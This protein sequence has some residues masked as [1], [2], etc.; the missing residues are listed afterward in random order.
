M[1]LKL[2]PTIKNKPLRWLVNTVFAVLFL[3]VLL[4]GAVR[5]L[6]PY[7]DGQRAR[8]EQ[9][10]SNTLNATVS[11]ERIDSHWDGLLPYLDLENVRIAPKKSAKLQSA[12]T[13]KRLSIGADVLKMIRA[14]S[15][16][17]SHMDLDGLTVILAQ[18]AKGRWRV[19]GLSKSSDD[20]T[21]TNINWDGLIRHKQVSVK[22]AQLKIK[23]YREKER[24]WIRSIQAELNT[25]NGRVQAM[26]SLQPTGIQK[27]AQQAVAKVHVDVSGSINDLET[28]SGLVN[29]HIPKTDLKKLNQY[30]DF[31][32]SLYSGHTRLA[33]DIQLEDGKILSSQGELDAALKTPK[34]KAE[35]KTPIKVVDKDAQI[36]LEAPAPVILN[37]QPLQPL[38]QSRLE[39]DTHNGFSLGWRFAQLDAQKLSRGVSQ[40]LRKSKGFWQTL[41]GLNIKGK[42][43][44]GFLGWSLES[45]ITAYGKMDEVSWQA[46]KSIPAVSGLS[47]YVNHRGERTIVTMDDAFTYNGGTLFPD[48]I[49]VTQAKGELVFDYSGQ[50]WQ[51][52]TTDFLLNTAH[53]DSQ[54]TV[55][56]Q[57]D[58]NATPEIALSSNIQNGQLSHAMRYVPRTLTPQTLAWFKQAFISGVIPNASVQVKGPVNGLFEKGKK[59]TFLINARVKDADFSYSKTWPKV[60]KVSGQFKMN[61]RRLSVLSE[62]GD[63]LGLKP[64]EVS[65]VIPNLAKSSME[66]DIK[67]SKMPMSKIVYFLKHSP[68]NR[69]IG[70]AISSFSGAGHA[71]VEFGMTLPLSSQHYKN[72]HPKFSGIAK[73][74]N[75]QLNILPINAQLKQ[76]NGR[77]GFTQ[78]SINAKGVT[79]RLYGSPVKITAQTIDENGPRGQ[80]GIK[81]RLKL[82]PIVTQY[83]KPIERYVNGSSFVTALVDLPL[84]KQEK[85]PNIRIQSSLKGAVISLPEPF[86]LLAEQKR[87]LNA[88]VI[89]NKN[90][91]TVNVNLK[92][93]LNSRIRFVGN[94]S[95]KGF[96]NIQTDAANWSRKSGI[97][98]NLG[99]S[100]LALDAWLPVFGKVYEQMSPSSDAIINQVTGHVQTM[101]LGRMK[102]H[103]LKLSGK[104]SDGQWRFAVLSNELDGVVSAPKKQSDGGLSAWQ[105][106]LDKLILDKAF[107]QKV[108]IKEVPINPTQ[109]PKM[110]VSIKSLKWNK[111]A[112]Q[113]L[114]AKIRPF[115]QGLEISKIKV[116][117]PDMS[118][119]AHALWGAQN[120]KHISD[121]QFN[122]H[123]KDGGRAF[124]SLGLKDFF[125]GGNGSFS[126]H[127]KWQDAL[128]SPNYPTLEGKVNAYM[129][130]GDLLGINPGVGR[131]FAIMNI[132]ALPKRLAFNFR[133][134]DSKGLTFNSIAAEGII[135]QG[136]LSVYPVAIKTD[137]GSVDLH[138]RIDIPRAN[139]D[140]LAEVNPDVSTVLP[141]AAGVLGGVPGL[142]GG[143]LL[144]KAVK[145]FGK[146]TDT[147][148]QVRYKITGSIKDP[149]VES[150]KVKRVKDLTPQELKQRLQEI[151]AQQNLPFSGDTEK[152]ELILNE[153]D[154][155]VLLDDDPEP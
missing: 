65:F 96:V 100:N 35:W 61:K 116:S 151:Q 109:V 94:Q 122:A 124:N 84:T 2:L 24:S 137:M 131:L 153:D 80:L 64:D 52:N 102:V 4:L 69:Y 104:K 125:N 95:P 127:V 86:T 141:V 92:D 135:Q 118:L 82:K 114:S 117:N 62:S 60:N 138:G 71:D 44:D 76:L 152:G 155:K 147:V 39:L 10:L 51:F 20:D 40:T 146:N 66:L 113:N 83:A 89:F 67:G 55:S 99:Q 143:F 14:R 34:F 6:L 12:Q 110:D 38:A 144:S 5:L 37:G 154:E 87:P 19:P 33:L 128:Y 27:R 49:P 32:N 45:G 148:A 108:G 111:M 46:N 16:V 72:M 129:E 130:N 77:L 120:Q 126:G 57:G 139:L 105:L 103:N 88:S 3:I 150:T 115:A 43:N 7:A 50:G 74:R 41:D 56:I 63:V 136:I 101:S 1:R 29:V 21:N 73:L 23:P 91:Q 107:D 31:S 53:L 145:L 106:N 48:K 140:M 75:A 42:V 28:W 85:P 90:A 26:L 81:G 119:Q 54:H 79:G 97:E 68:I 22:N 47:A 15:V 134:V 18:D 11:I 132:D 112:L 36:L 30:F 59:S 25:G 17:P 149:K 98:L 121:V 142:V 78:E 9:E 58:D 123:L 93:T 133:D 8:L 13:L 70:G